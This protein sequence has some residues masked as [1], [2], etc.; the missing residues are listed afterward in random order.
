MRH[1]L[2]HAHVALYGAHVYITYYIYII[3]IPIFV[4]LDGMEFDTQRFPRTSF[5]NWKRPTNGWRLA[6]TVDTLHS[7]IFCRRT[8]AEMF[9]LF[10]GMFIRAIMRQ[11]Q[12]LQAKDLEIE[13]SKL[14]KVSF[15]TLLRNWVQGPNLYMQPCRPATQTS[16]PKYASRTLRCA[17]CHHCIRT[18]YNWCSLLWPCSGFLCCF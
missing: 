3:I 5:K 12:A 7:Q 14:R 8:H 6:A 10:N 13:N 11:T 17:T 15:S 4:L 1:H 16:W 18:I 2:R 9:P